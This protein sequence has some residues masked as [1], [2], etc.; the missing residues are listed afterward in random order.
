MMPVT[1]N[2]I[3]KNVK[4]TNKTKL[5]KYFTPCNTLGIDFLQGCTKNSDTLKPTALNE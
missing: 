2:E 3:R 1:A 5:A 4:Y